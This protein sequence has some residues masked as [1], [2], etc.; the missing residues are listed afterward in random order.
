MA[1]FVR[2]ASAAAALLWFGAAASG[3]AAG[4]TTETYRDVVASDHPLAYY[5]LDERSGRIARDSGPHH[6]DGTIGRRVRIGRPSL[7]PDAAR[8]MEFEGADVTYADDDVRVPRSPL[9]E[10]KDAIT[11]EL[12]VDPYSV[13]VR[14]HNTGDIT[15]MSYGD[16]LNP[17]Q[18]HCR[19]ELG[20][21]AHSHVFNLQ[22]VI[23][24]HSTE[25]LSLRHPRGLVAGLIDRVTG[26]KT[27]AREMYAASG[28]VGAPP[29][30]HHLYQLAATYDGRIITMYVNGA[31]NAVFRVRGTIAG[32][33]AKDGLS[34]G[35]EYADVNPAF[36]G[37]ISEVSVYDHVLTPERILA[38]YRAGVAG[39]R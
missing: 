7:I 23:D 20:L 11:Y 39:V 17:D 15:L 2:L 18:Q 1:R 12:W 35:G 28:S 29:V 36:Y 25:P 30:T 32:Y 21:D 27:R 9:F 3:G 10:M 5:R 6:L 4:S 26:D 34:V 22:M 31:A 19:W 14:G 33:S 16:D 13:T 38:H 24:G 37:R 8:S